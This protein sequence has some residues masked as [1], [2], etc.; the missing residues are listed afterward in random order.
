[1]RPRT[2]RSLG[3]SPSN[4]ATERGLAASVT[5]SVLFAGVY[6]VTPQLAPASAESIW[7]IR[8]LLTI[9]IVAFALI[10]FRQ[11][12]LVSDVWYRVK[13]QPWLLLPLFVCGVIVS[14][15]LWV[16]SWAPLNGRGLQVALGYF[17]LPL[18]LVVIGRLLYK[19][20]LRW[21]HWLAAGVAAAGVVFEIVR[22]GSISWETLLVA[23][24]YPIYFVLRKAIG[25]A[26]IGGML[27]EFMLVMPFAL[28]FVVLEV[29][30]GVTLHENPSLV[31]FAPLFGVWTAMA[32][33]CY[34]L[35]SR[36]LSISIFGL[37]SYLEPALLVV[38]S[39]LIGERILAAE[40]PLY[41]AVWAAVGILI[42]GGC[43]ML[44]ANARRAGPAGDP[45]TD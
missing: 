10:A 26:H 31:W 18:V 41:I 43:F 5:S 11:W 40:W 24:G 16:F 34:L 17:L 3:R 45:H 9:P 32:L 30:N 6:F 37:M 13:K 1:M 22:V 20:A 44:V 36:Y 12:W 25:S 19:D 29:T 8:N 35:A 33:I 21:W 27:W 2:E 14:A 38:A 4:T 42:I 28:V 7:G 23:L 15:Q 39:L